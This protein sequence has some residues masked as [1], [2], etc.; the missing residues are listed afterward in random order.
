[1]KKKNILTVE[2]LLSDI[3]SAVKEFVEKNDT[4]GGGSFSENSESVRNQFSNSDEKENEGDSVVE[5]S[6]PPKSFPTL[7]QSLLH[8]KSLPNTEQIC[9]SSERVLFEERGLKF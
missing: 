8:H 7:S 2:N 1:M 4:T 9:S 5:I 6:P 3:S